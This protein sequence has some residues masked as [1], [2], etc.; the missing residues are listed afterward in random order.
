ML[1]TLGKILNPR[2]FNTCLDVLE[3]GCNV[4]GFARMVHTRYRHLIQKTDLSSSMWV[5]RY[6]EAAHT[7]DGHEADIGS[8]RRIHIS[9]HVLHKADLLGAGGSAHV[10]I[11]ITPAREHVSMSGILAR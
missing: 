11:S 10:R 6:R 3:V 8:T 2:S 4:M 1:C 5:T 9:R 7:A